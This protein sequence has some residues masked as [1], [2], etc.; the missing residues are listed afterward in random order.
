MEAIKIGKRNYAFGLRWVDADPE[1]KPAAQIKAATSGAKARYCVTE[2]DDG[3]SVI[4]YI[5]AA[6][7]P[8][9]TLYSYA[10]ALASNA[11]N[12]IYAAELPT[13]S[14]SQLW[15]VVVSDHMVVAET[16]VVM[17]MAMGFQ[18][19]ETLRD[20]FALP[21]FYAG[22]PMVAPEFLQG[23]LHPF[24]LEEAVEGAKASPLK[25]SGG[26]TQMGGIVVLGLV[27][28]GVGATAWYLFKPAKQSAVTGDD[29]VAMAIAARAQYL[30]TMRGLLEQQAADTG[31]V[32]SAYSLASDRFPPAV[33]G[34][35]QEGVTC[36][37]QA[38]SATYTVA[39]DAA[40]AV[41]PMQ[42]R[43]GAANVAL[44]DDKRS[45][46]INM[47]LAVE[48][49]RWTDDQILAPLPW[50][51]PA[52]DVAGR[53]PM[54]FSR[55]DVENGV[56]TNISEGNTPPADTLPLIEEKI[57][58]KQTAA[59]EPV[60]LGALANFFGNDG[61]VAST[62]AVSGGVGATPSAYRIEF[63]RYGGQAR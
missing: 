29:P 39:A 42:A 51:R 37:P 10:Q 62:L 2:G 34:W 47:P 9:G 30:T 59:L 56:T 15:Y 53:L 35:R 50:S 7:A 45:L 32:S 52:T 6:G 19:L 57:A 36:T 22:N 16:D 14:G 44:M 1:R 43:F 23:D 27:L 48:K 20:A 38:C 4:G 41:A 25:P 61:F 40:Y 17:P 33:A 11:N 54:Y 5:E 60:R 58:V 26:S 24:P 8:K 55:L 49:M 31:W 18:T 13:S 63:V 28:A 46:K 21:V 12:G 3:R